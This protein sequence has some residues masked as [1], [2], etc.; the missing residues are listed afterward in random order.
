MTAYP[1]H[2]ADR[3]DG[4]NGDRASEQQSSIN[5]QLR[6]TANVIPAHVWYGTPS[7]ALVFVNSRRANYLGLPPD[8]PLRFGIDPGGEWDSHIP[9]LHLEDHE[10]ARRVWSTCFRTEVAFRVRHVEGWY[11]CFLSRAEPV[12]T[13][14]G[15]ML[16]WIEV[17]F[18]IEVQKR[19]EQEHRDLV[20]IIQAMV[21]VALPDG[22]NIYLNRRYVEYFG[23]TSTQTS[24]IGWPV[25]AHPD[26]LQRH[27]GA[28]PLPA[29]NLVKV[30]FVFAGRMTNIDGISTAARPLR[31]EDGDIV[32]RKTCV[33]VSG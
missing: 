7:S 11:R 27:E 29:V 32:K 5:A 15:T 20:D 8:H 14:K 24:G 22:S 33:M 6:A 9:S 3:V 30:R 18:D 21:W 10:V 12:R 25:A 2:E 31:D 16:C 23:M 19:A 17:N 28:R 26:D 13:A 4:V 1:Q